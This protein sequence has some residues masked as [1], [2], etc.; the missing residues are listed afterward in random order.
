VSNGLIEFKDVHSASDI[1]G[2]TGRLKIL[3]ADDHEI[4]LDML[5]NLLEPEFEVIAQATDG[6][7]LLRVAPQLQPDV[8]VIDMVMPG[9]SG[10]DAGR[11]LHRKMPALKLVYLSMETDPARAAAAF[12]GGASAYLSKACSAV[13]LQQAIRI[14]AG[15]G[16]YLTADIA[17]GDVEK[18]LFA[19]HA[20]PITKL[21]T[22]ELEV[23]QLLVGGLS[24]KS[25]GRRLGIAPRTVAFH[26][27]RAMEEL[28]LRSNV[29]L[30]DFAIRHGL[31][32][33]RAFAGA[34]QSDSMTTASGNT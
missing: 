7:T 20:S 22:R 19:H 18:L 10:L 14:V 29:E 6:D 5:R 17:D 12:A 32:R 25:V 13:E 8:A 15:G 24:M 9:I 33:T 34:L 4:L 28:G 11:E 3:L 27:Y 26:K 31:L 1:A 23:L 16:C 21:S 30:V 2:R